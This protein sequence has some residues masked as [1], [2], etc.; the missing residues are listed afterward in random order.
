[1]S[2]KF[3]TFLIISLTFFNGLFAQIQE[4]KTLKHTHSSIDTNFFHLKNNGGMEQNS[5]THMT[6]DAMGQMWFATKN[7]LI[8]FD[9]KNYFEY[10]H[11]P[12]NPRSIGGNFV[13]RVFVAKNGSIWVGTEP[14][15]LS[16]YNVDTDDFETI[17]GIEGK[18]IKDIKEDV[19]GLLWITSDQNLYSYNDKN[20]DLKT[21]S[22]KKNVGF[23]RLLIS[24]ENRFFITTNETYF[25]EF[26][27]TNGSFKEIQIIKESERLFTRK[28]ATYSA[29]LFTEDY[30]KIIWISTPFGYLV[31]FNP[32]TNK[33]KKFVYETE[34][35]FADRLT[36]MFILEDS[37]H[38]LWF[39]TWFNGL[40]KISQSRETITR[41]MPEENN[42]NSL[43]N[44]I[45]HSGFQDK[46]GYLWFG[47]EFA[48]IN[49]LRK[50]KK[51]K[52]TSYNSKD[53]NSLPSVAYT[54]AI[55]DVNNRV[56]IGTEGEG[57]YYFDIDNPNNFY[58]SSTIIDKD[59]QVYSLIT[60]SNNFLWIGTNKGLYKYNPRTKKVSTYLHNKDDYNSIINGA[61]IALEEDKSG[62]IWIGTP[63]GLTKFDIAKNK[64]Y[65]FSNEK[66][67]PKSLSNNIVRVIHADSNN[68]LWV[69]TLDGLNKFNPKTGNFTIFKH[70]Y[71]D[72]NT[73]SANRI[74]SIHEKD[75]ILWIG[76]Y[77][78][79]LTEYNFETKKFKTY[80]KE[81]GLPDNN[82]KSITN[83]KNNLWL[84]T[85]K[86]IIKFNLATKQFIN[87][88]YSDGLENSMYVE[89]V[90]LQD[91]EF[92]SD[93]AYTDKNNYLYF[94][95]MSGIT[96]F[97][98]DSLQNNN[99][100]P[101]ITIT[102]FLVNG[103]AKKTPSNK[104]ITL[105]ANQNH[106][107]I[108]IATLNF[109]QPEK[110]KIAYFLENKDSSWQFNN[111][112]FE[113]EYV[114]L[115][116]GNYTFHYKGANND[117]VWN[118]TIQPITIIISEPFYK[119]TFF[120]S[121]LLAAVLLLMGIFIGHKYYIKLQ[122]KKDKKALRY[123]TSNLT[124][125]KANAIN[126]KLI[127]YLNNHAPYL[128]ADLTLH[129]LAHLIKSKP[130]YLS[131]VIN[132]IHKSSFQEFIN[133]YRIK[134]AKKLLIETQLKIEAV[135]YDSGFNSI[136][137]FNAVFKKETQITPS[138]FR[139][140]HVK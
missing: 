22:Y 70:S 90:G 2:L 76:S 111:S 128:E 72:K 85:T 56:W 55:K 133:T 43:S 89:N 49:I 84:S 120:Y 37:K 28:T 35:K 121:T 45:I 123:S 7:G 108:E 132:Q 23:D 38:N 88:N 16:K 116:S 36:V 27:P 64:F 77:G 21:Y 58:K 33:L 125:E 97:H 68:D 59:T 48:G 93:F 140:Q 136:S 34:W 102:K 17:P 62:N 109:I 8:R 29:Y 54:A 91:L 117:G 112:N 15:V 75:G 73:I 99:Y 124:S 119:T 61:V 40:Y 86:N 24:S 67:N 66:D 74:N 92:Y 83:I 4:T 137:T 96:I 100:K 129:K 6:Q 9:S 130:H 69:G 103:K 105:K 127:K 60:A 138:Q 131:Q 25:L 52:I 113:I 87:Y 51:F 10:K 79:G 3:K 122:I 98:P 30:Q 135:V 82:V 44:S 118:E 5:F 19:D 13:E 110:N 20:K 139:K 114:D 63:N 1:M 78:G 32:E 115:P 39:G 65:R 107:E 81:D 95:G 31:Q 41:L 47:T 101:P 134:E 94:G 126:E 80:L 106:L 12:K 104:E 71:E 53:L 42:P 46:A 26:N 57:L 50:N 14:A 18:R 11:N